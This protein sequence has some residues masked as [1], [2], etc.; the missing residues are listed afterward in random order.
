MF[1]TM[2]KYIALKAAVQQ[3]VILS[4]QNGIRPKTAMKAMI[5]LHLQHH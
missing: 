3:A 5:H 1:G 4:E 2:L